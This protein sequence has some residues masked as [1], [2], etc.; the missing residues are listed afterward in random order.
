MTLRDTEYVELAEGEELQGLWATDLQPGGTFVRAGIGWFEGVAGGG[1]LTV[2]LEHHDGAPPY[3]AGWDDLAE[4]PY[5]SR[6]GRVK[7][8]WLDGGS[9]FVELAMAGPGLHRL[10]AAR[11]LGAYG[12]DTWRLQFWPDPASEPPRWLRRSRPGVVGS[13]EGPNLDVI[14]FERHRCSAS[15]LVSMILWAGPGWTTTLDDLADRLGMPVDD[16]RS[17]LRYTTRADLV[18]AHGSVEG[19][20]TLTVTAR[21]VR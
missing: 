2:H 10:R 6:C 4:T 19:P 18:A 15:D 1:P 11:R 13:V 3:D 12:A 8:C 17:T 9:S 14:E 21:L 5:D 20:F 16:V 7:V